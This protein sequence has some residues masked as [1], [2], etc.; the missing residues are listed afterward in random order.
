MAIELPKDAEGREIPLDTVALFGGNGNAYSIRRWVYTTDFDLGDSTAGQ[1]HALTDKLTRLDPELMYLNQP[2]SWEKLLEDLDR[3]ANDS[4]DKARGASCAW[5]HTGTLGCVDCPADESS[6]DSCDV[7]MLQDIA[8][9]IR[10]L[11]D[12]DE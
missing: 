4:G 7:L 11:R 10:K 9:R 12:E 2:D 6:D 1:W 8:S 5:F 3:A